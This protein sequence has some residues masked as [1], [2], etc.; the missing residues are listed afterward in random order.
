MVWFLK[1]SLKFQ[2]INFFFCFQF[3]LLFKSLSSFSSSLSKDNLILSYSSKSSFHFSG[4][5]AISSSVRRHPSNRVWMASLLTLCP[6][7]TISCLL[8]LYSQSSP[9]AFLMSSSTRGSDLVPSHSSGIRHIQ[10][11]SGSILRTFPACCQ[12]P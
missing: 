1:Y 7:N 9:S 4:P 10:G 2:K 12:P 5:R 6:M 11:L 3:L 8:S